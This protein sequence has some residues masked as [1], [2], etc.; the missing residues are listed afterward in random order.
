MCA[1]SVTLR[2]FVTT[3][4]NI[5]IWLHNNSNYYETRSTCK[6][7]TKLLCN[8]SEYLINSDRNLLSRSRVKAKSQRLSVTLSYISTNIVIV[9]LHNTMIRFSDY[10][11]NTKV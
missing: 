1:E 2:V 9:N 7:V 8:V 11:N 4:P 6:F 3:K 10:L 5:A